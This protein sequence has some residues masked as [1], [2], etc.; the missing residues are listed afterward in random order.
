VVLDDL[1]AGPGAR[2]NVGGQIARGLVV[3]QHLAAD[4][5]RLEERLLRRELALRVA[6]LDVG[7]AHRSLDV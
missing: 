6:Q 5:A 3:L 4:Q 1:I 7:L 2:Q